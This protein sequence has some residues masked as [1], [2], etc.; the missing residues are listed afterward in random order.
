E[1][2]AE[3]G[4]AEPGAAVPGAAPVD[5]RIH[6]LKSGAVS[7][8]VKACQAGFD[9][10]QVH[11]RIDAL[12]ASFEFEA[13]D[14]G[15]L[16]TMILHY[17]EDRLYGKAED[18]LFILAA[19]AGDAEHGFCLSFY[20]RLLIKEDVELAKGGLPRTEVLEGLQTLKGQWA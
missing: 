9:L 18:F 10:T 7:M 15:L 11:A 13:G 8:L 17:E 1:R 2:A 3:P 12:V 4:S 5:R 16:R 20:D 19:L 6:G 14:L